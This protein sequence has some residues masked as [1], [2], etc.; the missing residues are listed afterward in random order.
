VLISG[1]F[2]HRAP[3]LALLGAPFDVDDRRPL[4]YPVASP[5]PWGKTRGLGQGWPC[6]LIVPGFDE[7]RTPQG[8][9]L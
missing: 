6:C 7:R 9:P 3:M 1:L 2:Q 5:P 4:D 8:S